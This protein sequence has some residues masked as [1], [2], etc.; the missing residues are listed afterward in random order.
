M[1]PATCPG[2]TCWLAVSVRPPAGSTSHWRA[3]SHTASSAIQ[4]TG[5]ASRVYE[6]EVTAR[7]STEPGRRAASTPRSR[8]R[9][10]AT[11][12]ATAHN[13]AD[14]TSRSPM[15]CVTGC[16]STLEWPRSPVSAEVSQCHQRAT[17]DSSTPRFSRS[18]SR[19]SW[20]APSAAVP[21]YAL[22]GSKG[23][24][25][26]IANAPKVTTRTT[27]TANSARR[28]TSR[29]IA[30]QGGRRADRLTSS[31]A[32]SRCSTRARWRSRARAAPVGWS[33]RP[34]GRRGR[35]GGRCG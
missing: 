17:K 25:A 29:A 6:S 28:P 8:P 5:A 21:A 12:K 30:P 18:R 19:V 13:S 10:T 31:A 24:A 16:R 20:S 22:T 35:R 34:S 23:E 9:P 11:A 7:S 3:N 4:K 15:T 1:W 2:V 32:S 26:A 33:A 14:Q 27:G